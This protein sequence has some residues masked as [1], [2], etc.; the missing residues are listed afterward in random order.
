MRLP[1]LV[2]TPTF[3][4][5]RDALNRTRA[6]ASRQTFVNTRSVGV[7]RQDFRDWQRKYQFF[8]EEDSEQVRRV[9]W[10]W[11]RGRER[12]WLSTLNVIGDE[13]SCD[14]TAKSFSGSGCPKFK[15]P[16][17]AVVLVICLVLLGVHRKSFALTQGRRSVEALD[18]VGQ[19]SIAKAQKVP[20]H[21][22]IR[23]YG[24]A[25]P[26]YSDV[27]RHRTEV[28][29]HTVSDTCEQGFELVCL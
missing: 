21:A 29:E 8:Q 22:K 7:A 24:M 16:N 10:P 17:V 13:R 27:V 2:G 25:A 14:Q 3:M 28:G 6:V 5:R 19:F 11:V 23:V 12:F 1:S 9:L 18:F 26:M 15:K 4:S 20:F